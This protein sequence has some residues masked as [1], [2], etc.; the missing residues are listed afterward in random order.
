MKGKKQV[1]ISEARRNL[2]SLVRDVERGLTVALTRRGEPVAVV[3]STERYRAHTK[4]SVPWS[5]AIRDFRRAFD[6]D[7]LD[8]ESV[9]KDV[10]D[11]SGGREVQF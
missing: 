2:P 10:R 7:E 6:L 1:T 8:I 9:Y 4:G 5:R 3:I 11:R